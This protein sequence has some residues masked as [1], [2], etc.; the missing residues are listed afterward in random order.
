MITDFRLNVFLTVARTLSF[1]KT[2]TILCVSQPS[3]SKHI[4]ELESEIGESLF[5]RGGNKIVLTEKAKM[6]IPLVQKIMEE[7]HAL[8]EAI[9]QNL[10]ELSEGT[11]HIGASTTI[12]QYVLPSILARFG[13]QYPNIKLS[14]RSANSDEIMELLLK[15]EIEIALIEDDHKHNAVCYRHLAHDTLVL[16]STMRHKKALEK[17]DLSSIPLLIR[18]DGSGTLSVILRA[19]NDVGISR[20]T[21]NIKIQLGSSTAIIGYLK[22]SNTYAF[23][24]SRIV[25]KLVEKGIL[26]IIKINELEIK[27]EFRFATLH[28]QGGRLITLFEEFCI[29]HYHE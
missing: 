28:G 15:K 4:K 9:T 27:R 12:S 13:K 10:K 3:I 8:N 19:L 23:V 20:K 29:T 26:N 14:V 1:T 2:A 17:S 25:Q 22:E 24:S 7:Y 16:V 11:L 18:E 5:V 21:L 6:I